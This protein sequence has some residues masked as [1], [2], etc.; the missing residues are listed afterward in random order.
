MKA[1]L[2]TLG[3]PK[4]LVDSEATVTLLRRAGCSMT[5][6]PADADLLMVSA[7]SF[8]NASWRETLEEVD[9]LRAFKDSPRKKLVLMGCLP[10]HRGE[11]L[12]GSLPW[13]DHFLPTGAH[14]RLPDLV[15]AWRGGEAS[16]RTIAGDGTD[17]FAAFERRDLL[18]P[19]HTAYVKVAEGCNRGCTFCAIPLIRGRQESR[20]FDSIVREVDGLVARGVKEVSL[21]AQ[22]IV[23]YGDRGRKFVDL[24][25]AVAGTGVEWIRIYYFHPAGIELEYLQ[26]VFDH[27]SVVRYL[28]MPVQHAS[29]RILERMKRSHDRAHL[30]H[31]LEGLRTEIPGLVVRSEVIVGFPGETD[32][33]FDELK[34]FVE[35]FEF[36]SLGIF[37]Y[38][39]EPGTRAS[40]LDGSIDEDTK[41]S[42]VEELSEIQQAVSFGARSRFLGTTQRV[43]IDREVGVGEEGFGGCRYAG[44]FYGQALEVDGEVF[45][46]AGDLD[47]GGFVDVD[48]NDT[49]VFDLRGRPARSLQSRTAPVRE[50]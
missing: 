1:Y 33:D 11:D 42:R 20:A 10:K 50:E 5:D 27:P 35:E 13:V 48:I 38:S 23:A 44:R 16:E 31:L 30:E 7:C 21:L 25:G 49:G 17:R 43:L 46:E 8:L 15:E 39:R 47:V 9:R 2:V 32:D 22:D 26:R 37:P 41:R 18:T 28:E 14:G 36:D 40:E 6:S 4:N 3:C 45:V 19:G 12:E 34:A 24:V 29:T